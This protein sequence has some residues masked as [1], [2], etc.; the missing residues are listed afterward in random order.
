MKNYVYKA[1]AILAIVGATGKMQA[2]S[3]TFTNHTN[4]EIGVAMRYYGLGEPRYFRFIPSKASRQFTP[5]Q[6]TVPGSAGAE[7]GIVPAKVGFVAKTFWYV[8]MSDP[9]LSALKKDRELAKTLPWAE[10]HIT[11]MSTDAYKL[12]LALYE[13]SVKVG[14]AALASGAQVAIAAATSGASAPVQAAAAAVQA[15]VKGAAASGSLSKLITAV[16][17]MASRSMITDRHIDIIEDN[18]EIKFISKL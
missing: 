4:K 3:Y 16:G 7:E 1:L 6:P 15:G 9:K 11:W 10:I 12:A 2:W 13:S 18:G 8:D 14:G 17:E 5:G